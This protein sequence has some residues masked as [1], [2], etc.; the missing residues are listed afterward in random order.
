MVPEGGKEG[1]KGRDGSE[2]QGDKCVY[3]SVERISRV[4][5]EREKR[6]EKE[7]DL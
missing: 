1:G 4:R 3:V 7:E 5:Y 6:D 2:Q